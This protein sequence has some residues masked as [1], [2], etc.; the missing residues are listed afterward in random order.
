MYKCVGL[1]RKHTV[2]FLS[3]ATERAVWSPSADDLLGGLGHELAG[4]LVFWPV[5][6]LTLSE[7]I[8]Q[9]DNNTDI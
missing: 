7:N 6:H 9:Q 3:S 5:L 4:F 2:L 8:H 1:L